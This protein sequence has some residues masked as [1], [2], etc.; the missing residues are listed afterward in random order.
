MEERTVVNT[1][2]TEEL[3]TPAAPTPAP[4]KKRKPVVPVRPM[5]ELHEITANK[6]TDKERINYI[7]EMR[8]ISNRLYSQCNEY[9]QNAK[10]AFEQKRLYEDKYVKLRAQANQK[11]NHLVQILKT[12]YQSALYTGLLEEETEY[13]KN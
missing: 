8:L 13:G 11:L 4:K 10:S 9:E 12:S 6:M 3:V 1:D 2:A 5:D 7:E